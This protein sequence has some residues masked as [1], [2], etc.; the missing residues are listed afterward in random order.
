MIVYATDVVSPV[1]PEQ[2]GLATDDARV[3]QRPR[4]LTGEDVAELGEKGPAIYGDRR[5]FAGDQ[6]GVLRRAAERFG[7]VV[8]RQVVVNDQPV[9]IS[10]VR[11]EEKIAATKGGRAAREATQ[12]RGAD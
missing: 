12:I 1:I 7:R 3:P 6:K 10:R 2:P 5:G 9:V 11:I 8:A 4:F